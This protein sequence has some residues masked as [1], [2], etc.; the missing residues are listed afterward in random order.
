MISAILFDLGRVLVHYDSKVTVES[1]AS[2]SQVDAV[3]MRRFLLQLS[4][5]LDTGVLSAAAFHRLLVEQTGVA[6]SYA[7]FECAYCLALARDEEALAY[8]LA[9]PQRFPVKV[10]VISNTNYA[11]SPYVRR[12]LPELAYFD[13]VLLSNEVGLAKPD[14]TIYQ[15]ALQQLGV[16]AQAAIF[17]DDLEENVVAARQLGLTGIVHHSWEQTRPVL[18]ALLQ[19]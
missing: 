1:L 5:Q 16:P 19:A 7:Q 17:I 3:T 11:H 9:L 18:E 10:G 4:P 8:A 2:I 15:R 6:V 12:L 13:T 14:P